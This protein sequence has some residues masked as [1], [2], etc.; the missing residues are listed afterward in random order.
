MSAHE[1]ETA[2]EE[3]GR[4]EE[5]EPLADETSTAAEQSPASGRGSSGR[6]WRRVVK[7]VAIGVGITVFAL[8]GI[9]A[10]L[11]SFGGMERPTPEY[12]A[13]YDQ[14][15]TQGT[16]AP[17]ERRFVIPIPGCR[18]HSGDPVQQVQHSVYR[19]NECVSCHGGS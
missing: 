2:V 9:A 10:L 8:V 19:L 18:C 17:I 3:P 11:Y 13:A 7:R 14:M 16:A 15:V 4:V 1:T 6:N 5:R 12:R